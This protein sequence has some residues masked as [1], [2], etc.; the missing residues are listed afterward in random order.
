M[1]SKASR[2]L[3][4]SVITPERLTA[5][6]IKRARRKAFSLGRE[7]IAKDLRRFED[8]DTWAAVCCASRAAIVAK[9]AGLYA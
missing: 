9:V 1:S 2:E 4:T 6:H 3:D 8:P 5:D 7:D